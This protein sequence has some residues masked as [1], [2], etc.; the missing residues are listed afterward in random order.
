VPRLEL[1]AW[2]QDI[3]SYRPGGGESCALAARRWRR[4]SL[5]LRQTAVE[6]ALAVTHG[7]LIRVALACEE[8]LTPR[9]LA[10][11]PVDFG[12]VHRLVLEDRP[13]CLDA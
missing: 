3:W 6:V 1:D 5:A 4:W 9:N 11:H 12:S 10:S 8:I 2:A 7:G 13:A